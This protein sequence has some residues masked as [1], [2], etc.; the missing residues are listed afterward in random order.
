MQHQVGRL[1][2][3]LLVTSTGQSVLHVSLQMQ[4]AAP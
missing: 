2:V 1:G 4:G 3:E